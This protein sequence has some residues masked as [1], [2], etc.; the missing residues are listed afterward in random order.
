[1]TLSNHQDQP[2]VMFYKEGV[3]RNFAKFIGKHLCHGLFFNNVA[4]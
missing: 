3:P 4:G 2:L 1:M